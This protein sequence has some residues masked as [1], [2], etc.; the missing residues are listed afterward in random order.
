M[1]A[2]TADAVTTS[3]V[4]MLIL[5]NEPPYPSVG[6][7]IAKQVVEAAAQTFNT[8]LGKCTDLRSGQ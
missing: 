2:T 8:S 5:G 1:P 6:G 7:T 3:E 4:I